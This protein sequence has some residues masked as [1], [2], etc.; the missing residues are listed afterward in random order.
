[1]SHITS[2]LLP[3]IKN[4]IYY[5]LRTKCKFHIKDI[6]DIFW[7]SF[8]LAN[9]NLN[10]RDVVYEE[11]YKIIRCKTVH[12]G[13]TMFECSHCDNFIIVPHTC[14]SRFC[15]S[16][17]NKYNM[18][19]SLNVKT[20]VMNVKHRHI[21]FTIP[22]CL[23]VIFLEHREY[24][25]DLF[26]AVNET[27][28]WMFNPESYK[29]KEKKK[30][31]NKRSKKILRV[32]KDSCVTP[33]YISTI[34]TYGRDLKWNPH[35]HVLISEGGLTNATLKYKSKNYFDYSSL[36]KTFQKILLDKLYKRLGRS[37][38]PTKCKL[39]KEH[40][41]GFYVHGPERKFKTI[42]K[43]IEYILR[44]DGKPAMAES[45]IIDVD[46]DSELITYWYD[47]HT[48]GKRI[49]VKEHV[50]SFIAKLIRHIPDRNFKN[51][52][53]YGVYALKNHKYRNAYH[54][55]YKQSIIRKQKQM[56]CWRYYLISCF[57]YDPL[58]C[59]CGH[60]LIKTYSYIPISGSEDEW[61]EIK[62]SKD[63]WQ[64]TNWEQFT[65][66]CPES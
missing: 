9:P 64:I 54:L 2:L 63:K 51:V 47:D 13:Y 23:R 50:Y 39:Y 20:K 1:M 52:R 66:Y 19:R 35:I 3:Y 16:C 38:Y 12:L 46:Y 44:Y 60:E 55:M 8:L 11:V 26:E 10:I 7:E 59:E 42:E 36:R 58:K 45:R 40:N 18:D 34:H 14:K 28:I 32:N 21:V 25:N 56:A 57:N 37:F 65:R 15:S 43:T 48:T 17:G 53:Y 4:D 62:Y 29:N 61:H 6:F 41:N 31:I 49:E 5:K 22:E 33:G 24:L 30:A 27:F